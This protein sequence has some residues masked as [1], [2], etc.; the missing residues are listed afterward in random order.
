MIDPCCELASLCTAFHF[1][2]I[3]IYL[4]TTKCN[5]VYSHFNDALEQKKTKV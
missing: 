1:F 3:L 2:Y 4:P 5:L